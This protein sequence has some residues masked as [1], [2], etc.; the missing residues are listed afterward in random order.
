MPEPM[1]LEEPLAHESQTTYGQMLL[2]SVHESSPGIQQR[3]P[4]TAW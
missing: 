3:L 2:Y 1:V 4:N